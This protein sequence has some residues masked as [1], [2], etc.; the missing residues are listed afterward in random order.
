[1]DDPASNIDGF[2]IRDPCVSSIFLCRTVWTKKAYLY[3][4][5][6]KLQDEVFLEKLTQ[7]SLGNNALD[8]PAF[9]LDRF[10]YRGACVSSTLLSRPIWT[11]QSLSPP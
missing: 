2:L 4:E 6:A 9:N 11:K 5:T 10:L 1:M 3:L 8:A 7:F